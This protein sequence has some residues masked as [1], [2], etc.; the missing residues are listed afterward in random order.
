MCTSK[1]KM[2]RENTSR[3]SAPFLG[4]SF[5]RFGLVFAVQVALGGGIIRAGPGAVVVP[6]HAPVRTL[7][8]VRDH[9]SH[10]QQQNGEF[11]YAH[12]PGQ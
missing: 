12:P 2:G 4:S 3:C 7:P 10:P 11:S 8:E 6:L 1:Q 5:G 9:G